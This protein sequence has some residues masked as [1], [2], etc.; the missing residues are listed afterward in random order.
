VLY[1]RLAPVAGIGLLAVT[2]VHLIDGSASLPATPYIG[3]LELALA[4]FALPVA[5]ML[6]I[7]PVRGLWA[8]VGG[9]TLLAL[10]VYI[11][12]RTVGLPGSTD[13]IGNWTQTLGI[14]NVA[15]ELFV[16]ARGRRR[17]RRSAVPAL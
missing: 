10:V 9:V 2:V 14:L 17:R 3:I 4:A 16:L 1:R 7:R 13:D 11:A 6:I 12:S 15:T 8:I 5:V